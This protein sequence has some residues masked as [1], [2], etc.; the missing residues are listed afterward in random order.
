MIR[1]A[2]LADVPRMIELAA[3][4]R[5]EYAQYQ[6]VFWRQA[7]DAGQKQAPYFAELLQ[8]PQHIVLV[9]EAQE[10]LAGFVIAA[11]VPAPPVYDPGGLTC[12][13]DDF[14]V[15]ESG[16]WSTVGRALLDEVICRAKQRGAVQIVVVCARLDVPKRSML[17]D[18]GLPVASEWRTRSI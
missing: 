9:D 15:A 18:A 7:S 11:I 2:G 17:E 1:D 5:A 10:Q 14:T 16:H 3:L 8:N 13:V 12:V 6:P 4:K